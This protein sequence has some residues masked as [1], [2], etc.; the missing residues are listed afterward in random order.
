MR[1]TGRM[2]MINRET[3]KQAT[4]ADNPDYNELQREIAQRPPPYR[5]DEEIA[6][7]T[8]I[9][10]REIAEIGFSAWLHKQ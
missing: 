4:T 6:R 1:Y 5:S 9:A 10:R 2:I 8:A 7:E 3:G